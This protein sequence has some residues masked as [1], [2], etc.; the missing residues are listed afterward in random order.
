M[1]IPVVGRRHQR[2]AL[3]TQAAD[4]GCGD[5][6]KRI[7]R[8]CGSGRSSINDQQWKQAQ[9][10][11]A[12]HNQYSLGALLSRGIATQG[13]VH[14]RLLQY[15]RKELDCA[16][17]GKYAVGPD[18]DSRSRA[19]AAGNRGRK[20][21]S[22]QNQVCD[23]GFVFPCG[24]LGVL[25]S[26]P[27]LLRHSGR[28]WRE[29][30]AKYGSS[31]QFQEPKVAV[32]ID[33]TASRACSDRARRPRSASRVPGCRIGNTSR[34]TGRTP[35]DG[36]RFQQPGLRHPTFLLL[37]SG[38]PPHRYKVGGLGSSAADPPWA[39]RWPSAV[40]ITQPLQPPR[41]LRLRVGK[42][43]GSQAAAPGPGVERE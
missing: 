23:V 32:E 34:R 21:N 35:L 12:N 33:R 6:S 14:A 43:Q 13:F 42:A 38:R 28:K 4:W 9:E 10:P 36:L 8:T 41:R 24:S 39:Q 37:A 2:E 25:W 15:V 19:V 16:P 1:G 18:Q 20:W 17:L 26:Q 31:C 3:T 11:T 7:C 30:R 27:D 29:E 40:E 22:G 5:I